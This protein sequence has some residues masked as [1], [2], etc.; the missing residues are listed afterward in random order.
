[1]REPTLVKQ[2]NRFLSFIERFIERILECLGEHLA[3]SCAKF[4]RHIDHLNLR[5]WLAISTA[6]HDHLMPR[7]VG[8]HPMKRLDRGRSRT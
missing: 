6:S 1:L 7:I 5:Q 4:A 3:V 2:Q 8:L